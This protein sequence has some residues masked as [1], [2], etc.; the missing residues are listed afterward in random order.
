MKG[1]RIVPWSET[2]EVLERCSHP[3]PTSQ[4][5]DIY[6]GQRSICAGCATRCTYE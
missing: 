4:M 3:N 6:A 2:K 1:P 5:S